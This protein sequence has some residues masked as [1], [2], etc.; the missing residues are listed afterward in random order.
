[1][2]NWKRYVRER[3]PDLGLRAER[4][5]EIVD[6]LAAHLEAAYQEALLCGASEQE[7][8]RLAA[9]QI[10]DWQL[11]ECELALMNRSSIG[12]RLE[13]LSAMEAGSQSGKRVRRRLFMTSLLQDLRYGLRML[14]KSPGFTVVAVLTLS[15]GIGANTA[16]FSVVNSVLLK[17]LAFR[18]PDRIVTLSYWSNKP[19]SS[20]D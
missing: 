13:R 12:E 15:L 16:M 19:S 9:A 20:R 2:P 6:E 11:L 18:N 4:E 17:P 1:M 3:L 10:K 8:Y 5:V 14:R 7:A